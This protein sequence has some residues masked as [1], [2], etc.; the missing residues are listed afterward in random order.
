MKGP[1]EKNNF[2]MMMMMKVKVTVTKQSKVTQK[3]DTN[4]SW[5]CSMWF[6]FY[7]LF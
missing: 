5:F 7:T 6:D 2:A 3:A 1:S 4:V